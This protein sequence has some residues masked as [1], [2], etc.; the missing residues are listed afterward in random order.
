MFNELEVP[1]G[2]CMKNESIIKLMNHIFPTKSVPKVIEKGQKETP[3]KSV[4]SASTKSKK[5]E[6]NPKPAADNWHSQLFLVTHSYLHLFFRLIPL[7]KTLCTN[8]I[9]K[10]AYQN[11]EN[12]VEKIHNAQKNVKC[13]T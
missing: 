13:R 7:S 3:Q 2:N 5:I 11:S 9:A 8:H 12:F 6:I 1:K 4:K 10:N